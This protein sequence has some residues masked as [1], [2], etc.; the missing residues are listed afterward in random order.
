MDSII[1]GT[2]FNT[3]YKR[4]FHFLIPLVLLSFSSC[5]HENKPGAHEYILFVNNSDRGVLVSHIP[6]SP[7]TLCREIRQTLSNANRY[8]VGAHS[9][10]DLALS[11]DRFYTT[12]ERYLSNLSSGT[13][14]VFVHDAIISDSIC[15][16]KNTNWRYMND[17]E[18][19][20]LYSYLNEQIIIKRYFLTV[21]D[22]ERLDWTIVYP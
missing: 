16:D 17:R 15:N 21:E 19:D 2:S 3:M 7:D 18:E 1:L 22:L 6:W 4:F 20:S 11:L 10:S 14:I 9:K 12:W 5:G 13:V 8:G